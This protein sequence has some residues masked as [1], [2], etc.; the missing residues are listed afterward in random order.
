MTPMCENI[1]LL[2]HLSAFTILATP[3]AWPSSPVAILPLPQPQKHHLAG[4][5][6]SQRLDS[7]CHHSNRQGDSGQVLLD[8]TRLVWAKAGK[9]TLSGQWDFPVPLRRGTQSGGPGDLQS[10]G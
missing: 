1:Q 6:I 10:C 3:S 4:I 2:G 7:H 9:P 8:L 5:N